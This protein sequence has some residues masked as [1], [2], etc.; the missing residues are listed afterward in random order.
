MTGPTFFCTKYNMNNTAANQLFESLFP[1]APAPAPR[2][3]RKQQAINLSKA[4]G[5]GLLA[6]GRLIGRGLSATA[7]GLSQAGRYVALKSESLVQKLERAKLNLAELERRKAVNNSS[8]PIEKITNLK[9]YIRG[10][11]EKLSQL[12]TNNSSFLEKFKFGNGGGKPIP[13]RRSFR[14]SQNIYNAGKE[15]KKT[16]DRKLL[17]NFQRAVLEL[18]SLESNTKQT[19]RVG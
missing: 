11:Q 16:K 15:Y 14:T 9:V 1:A 5:R 4:T 10:L 18:Q 6:T 3:N 7:G 2:P 8:V 19:T 12:P 17:A 13:R